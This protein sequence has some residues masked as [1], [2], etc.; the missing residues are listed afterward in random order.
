[1]GDDLGVGLGDEVVAAGDELGLEGEV[2][3]HDAVV[4][5]NER[6]GA[7][8]VRV[9]V[10]LRGAAVRGPAG[11]ADAEGSGDGTGGDGGLKV[12]QLAGGATQ[13]Q[14]LRASGD[15]DAG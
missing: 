13:L 4:H 10:L 12:A 6:S 3:L 14:A 1:V 2:V 9:G 5:D 8:A 15:G 7:V 11:V